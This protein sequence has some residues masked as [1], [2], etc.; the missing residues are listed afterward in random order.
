MNVVVKLMGGL[1]NQMFQYAFG[2]NISNITGRKLILD[3]SFLDEKNRGSGFVYRDYDLDVFNLNV[4]VVS[5]FNEPVEYIQEDW[6]LLHVFQSDLIEKSI[7]SKNK[8]IYIY[9]KW[10]QF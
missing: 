2:K 5:S 8:N 9:I 10:N 7:N 4:E 1:G 6:H 3:T